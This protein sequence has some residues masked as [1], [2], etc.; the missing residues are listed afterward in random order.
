MSLL[1]FVGVV[2]FNII[3]THL[4][5]IE[6]AFVLATL[7]GVAFIVLGDM[8]VIWAPTRRVGLILQERIVDASY[9]IEAHP[10]RTLLELL[11]IAVALLISYSFL[12]IGDLLISIQVGTFT[13][14]VTCVA[15]ELTF[16]Y[17]RSYE[18]KISE[19]AAGKW[20]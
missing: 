10:L 16:E 7:S 5:S 15:N 2:A 20:K 14:I 4:R 8:F 17:L 9:N 6:V 19:V 13:G 3:Y 1:G 11:A 12:W 18:R